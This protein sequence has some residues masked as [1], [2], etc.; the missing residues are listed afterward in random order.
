MKI[1][2][3]QLRQVIKEVMEEEL[4]HN[5]E[6]DARELD[7]MVQSYIDSFEPEMGEDAVAAASRAGEEFT[8]GKDQRWRVYAE[9]LGHSDD[10]VKG[11]VVNAMEASLVRESMIDYLRSKL[12]PSEEDDGF[13]HDPEAE[14]RQL[15]SDYLAKMNRL[16]VSLGSLPP[17]RAAFIVANRF[18]QDVPDWVA[19]SAE[20]GYSK[21]D[22]RTMVAEEAYEVLTHR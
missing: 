18:L 10:D 6:D 5:N 20:L 15:V 17:D 22:I 13:A 16:P 1:K 9:K 2:L 21:D 4:A 3:S 19:L 14:L 8:V 7:H 12:S 11:L